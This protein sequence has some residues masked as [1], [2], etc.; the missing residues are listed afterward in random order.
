MRKVI[1]T[2]HDQMDVSAGLAARCK[3]R[4]VHHLKGATDEEVTK[5]L[6]SLWIKIAHALQDATAHA[7]A[8]QNAQGMIFYPAHPAVG[9]GTKSAGS[10][11][12]N[13][14][15]SG[16]NIV[17]I[18]VKGAVN[19]IKTS[20]SCHIVLIV[21]SRISLVYFA[22]LQMARFLPHLNYQCPQGI[23]ES[24]IN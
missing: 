8:I 3:R 4:T 9:R 12:V 7:L 6:I 11:G 14:K 18:N 16:E 17:E 13:F 21:S 20:K 22:C 19:L 10:F 1:H 24:R 2:V 5:L 23:N 15:K